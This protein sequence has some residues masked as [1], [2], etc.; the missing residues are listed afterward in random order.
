MLA[1]SLGQAF[2][3]DWRGR[4]AHMSALDFVLWQRF[5]G[6][7]L[8]GFSRIY[9]D[10]GLGGETATGPDV[11]EAVAGAWSRLTAFRADVVGFALDHW[12]IIELRAAAG[13]GA[14]GS[15]ITY[16]SLWAQSPPD[17]LP[18]ELWLVTDSMSTGLKP[19]LAAAGIKLFLV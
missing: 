11:S 2:A 6:P 15:L 1:V 3:T 19:S 12:T 7:N 5:R 13:P 9:F 17:T 14:L 16:Q 10:V 4:P 8:G 18:V